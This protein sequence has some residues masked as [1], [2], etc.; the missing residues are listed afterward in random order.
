MPYLWK[1]KKKLKT[2]ERNQSNHNYGTG[3][4]S[5]KCLRPVHAVYLHFPPEPVILLRLGLRAQNS[6]LRG[7]G[8]NQGLL[9]AVA[10]SSAAGKTPQARAAPLTPYRGRTQSLAWRRYSGAAFPA[11]LRW[12]PLPFLGVRA[13][14]LFSICPPKISFL[15]NLINTN[16]YLPNMQP[17]SVTRWLRWRL[18]WTT[19]EIWRQFRTIR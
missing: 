12:L 9:I 2:K 6:Q 14:L 8:K 15:D 19:K 3:R 10:G 17:P 4:W 16:V 18:L 13:S 7:T 5:L 1:K 11:G